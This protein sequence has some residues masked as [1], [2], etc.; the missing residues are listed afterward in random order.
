MPN[1]FV[2]TNNSQLLPNQCLCECGPHYLAIFKLVYKN[3]MNYTKR[4][5]SMT[6]RTQ[7]GNKWKLC[8]L[9]KPLREQIHSELPAEINQP[10]NIQPE[11]IETATLASALK[12]VLFQ[13]HFIASV[14][15]AFGVYI[16]CRKPCK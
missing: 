15:C 16:T 7:S 2:Y 14:Q 12:V 11:T 13:G 9:C 4:T 3:L 5:T 1:M 10:A 6:D 8:N